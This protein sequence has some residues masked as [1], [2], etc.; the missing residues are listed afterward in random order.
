MPDNTEYMEKLRHDIYGIMAGLLEIL[1]PDLLDHSKK[2]AKGVKVFAQVLG[3]PKHVVQRVYVGGLVHDLGYLAVRNQ[4]HENWNSLE[5]ETPEQKNLQELHPVLGEAI[6]RRA[7]SF[8]KIRPIVRHHHEHY[9]GSGFPDGL[10][11]KDIPAEARLVAIV[12]FFDRVTTARS[13]PTIMSMKEAE[14]IL[15]ED[16]GIIYDPLMVPLFLEK[17]V[18]TGV[19]GPPAETD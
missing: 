6:L 13:D 8:D 4:A 17:V 12:D 11:G 1:N 19:L 16:A 18:P 15:K 9:D 2:V 14:L 7:R 5:D 3:W 10:S